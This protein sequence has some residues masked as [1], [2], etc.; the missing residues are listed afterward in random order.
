[1]IPSNYISRLR[2]INTLG[3]ISLS[4]PMNIS[5]SAAT[6]FG[7]LKSLNALISNAYSEI[8]VSALLNV[9]ATTNTDFIA[10]RPQS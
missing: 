3:N 4:N 10:L 1:M 9:P 2:A 5:I 6:I 7:V 8:V